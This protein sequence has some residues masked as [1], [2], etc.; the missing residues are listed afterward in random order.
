MLKKLLKTP[1]TVLLITLIV[2]GLTLQPFAHTGSLKRAEAAFALEGTQQANVFINTV[3]AQ[4]DTFSAQM[5]GLLQIKEFA[6][7]GLLFWFAKM[8][9][10]SMTQSLL[11]WINSGFQGS[12]AFIQDLEAFALDLADQTFG[13]FISQSNLAGLCEPFSLDVQIAVTN[14]FREQQS[15]AREYE[16]Q[17]RLSDITNNIEGFLNGDFIGGGGWPAWLEMTQRPSENTALGQKF[18]LE[19]R[20]NA[21]IAGVEVNER[22]LLDFGN[23]FLSVKRC[24]DPDNPTNCTIETPGQV[25]SEALTFQLSVGPR[26][27]IEADEIDELIS[28]LFQQLLNQALQGV[29]GLLGLTDG[30]TGFLDQLGNDVNNPTN[31][32]DPTRWDTDPIIINIPDTPPDPDDP[33]DPIFPGEEDPIDPVVGDP[34]MPPVDPVDPVVDT[35]I[36]PATPVDPPG[37]DPVG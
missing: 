34:D 19:A 26:T 37:V 14:S 24:E 1:S 28:A 27:L 21:K 17:C 25:I 11:T 23:G 29:G 16:A 20:L 4:V 13:E 7:D 35:P 36:D 12:P 8:I 30:P 3:N 33:F 6:L 2:A 5:T 9:L 31:R 32:P 15:N 10:Q 18:A 22:Q